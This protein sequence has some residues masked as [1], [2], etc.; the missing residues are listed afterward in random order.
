[1]HARYASSKASREIGMISSA[2]KEGGGN[3]RALVR[4]EPSYSLLRLNLR[5]YRAL[6]EPE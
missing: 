6:I 2:K 4:K 3:K 5:L 1:M